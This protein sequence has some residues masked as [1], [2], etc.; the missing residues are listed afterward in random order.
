MLAL[1]LALGALYASSAEAQFTPFD[2]P[3]GTA[4]LFGQVNGDQVVVVQRSNGSCTQ[5]S[6]MRLGGSRPFSNINAH[7]HAAIQVATTTMQWCG[8]T[9]QPLDLN[10]HS[11][12]IYADDL[13][14]V[15]FNDGIPDVRL[16]G[17]AADDLLVSL[18]PAVDGEWSA[19]GGG[20]NDVVVGA[21]DG[22]LEGADGNDI[23]CIAPN[24]VAQH[25]IGGAGFDAVC[26]ATDS[27]ESIEWHQPGCVCP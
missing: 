14:T 24:E 27:A 23:I 3:Q 10:G 2:I 11:I 4:A 18:I 21:Q 8:R 15:I 9:V 5:S 22:Y 12:A 25:V 1:A 13:S 7:G 6:I 20:G 16:F 17:G 26:G 19:H